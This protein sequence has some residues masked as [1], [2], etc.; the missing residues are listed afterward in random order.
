MS[1]RPAENLN[2]L[3]SLWMPIQVGVTHKHSESGN[4][5]MMHSAT[6]HMCDA[7][8]TPFDIMRHERFDHGHYFPI[9]NLDDDDDMATTAPAGLTS[10]SSL[11]LP[12]QVTQLFQAAVFAYTTRKDKVT[13]GFPL[14]PIMLFDGVDKSQECRFVDFQFHDNNCKAAVDVRRT[15]LVRDTD[16][17]FPVSGKGMLDV[18]IQTSPNTLPIELLSLG[19]LSCPEET[20]E[21]NIETFATVQAA[22][23]LQDSSPAQLLVAL[24]SQAMTLEYFKTAVLGRNFCRSED[25]CSVPFLYEAYQIWLAAEENLKET[26][27]EE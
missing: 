9:G 1:H 25:F 16:L 11:D 7:S 20:S 21:A 18:C 4:L 13:D 5:E 14:G 8:G 15:E 23:G 17:F 27:V 26:T 2:N 12:H 3:K 19:I 24:L 22:L 6:C 10:L